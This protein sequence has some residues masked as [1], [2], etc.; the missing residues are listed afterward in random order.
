[1][2]QWTDYYIG[3]FAAAAVACILLAVA[4]AYGGGKI[5][6]AT[7]H[8]SFSLGGTLLGCLVLL[9]AVKWLPGRVDFV[10]RPQHRRKH[11]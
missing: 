6:E 11:Q 2:R 3:R 10:L 4:L 9:L 1:M 5:T 7:G 8:E